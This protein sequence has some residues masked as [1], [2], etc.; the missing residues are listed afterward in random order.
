MPLIGALACVLPA[1]P[2]PAAMESVVEAGGSDGGEV[3]VE[4]LLI[5]RHSASVFVLLY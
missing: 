2:A 1:K 4:E 3:V 5:A